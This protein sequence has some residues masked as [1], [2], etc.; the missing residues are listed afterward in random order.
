MLER[1]GDARPFGWMYIYIQTPGYAG[2]NIKSCF[3]CQ[4]FTYAYSVIFGIICLK[5]NIIS[6]NTSFL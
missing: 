2:E 3:T 5:R 4:L 1:A 6:I